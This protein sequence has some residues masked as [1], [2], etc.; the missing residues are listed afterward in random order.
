MILKQGEKMMTDECPVCSGN[1]ISSM[2]TFTVDDGKSLIVIRN[3]PAMVCSLCGEEWI[4]DQVTESLETMVFEAKE[5]HRTIE[6]VDFNL[7][8]V[9]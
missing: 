5:K 6:V 3:T 4:S 1:K 7:E 9:A 2:V 8:D